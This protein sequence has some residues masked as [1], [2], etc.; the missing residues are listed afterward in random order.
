MSVFYGAKDGDLMRLDI[1]DILVESGLSKSFEIEFTA[2]DA[3]IAAN[4]CIFDKPVLLT[5]EVSNI[6]RI[7]RIKGS[8]STEYTTFCARCLKPVKEKISAR[9]D[10]EFSNTDASSGDWLYTYTGKTIVLD[11]V[12][13]DAII[14]KIPIRRLCREDCRALCP[15][16]GKDLN[17][18]SC[19]CDT[20]VYNEQFDVLREYFK[21]DDT[22][23]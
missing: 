22:K 18:G 23:R 17:Y 11:D 15:K 5:A 21:D 19:D 10:E 3:G 6:K 1:E 4:D 20:A 16:C 2:D 14:L 7:I 9:I 8:I 12:I 13:N